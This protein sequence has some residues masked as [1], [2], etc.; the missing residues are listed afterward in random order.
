MKRRSQPIKI[1]KRFIENQEVTP[2]I[3]HPS[4][5]GG[6]RLILSSMELLLSLV[7][8]ELKVGKRIKNRK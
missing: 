1:L 2:N 6:P 8:P 5:A 3:E 7:Q 4:S